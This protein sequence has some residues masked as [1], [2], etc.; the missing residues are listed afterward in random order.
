M[1][2]D[3]SESKCP[4]G[5]PCCERFADEMMIWCSTSLELNICVIIGNPHDRLITELI[6]FDFAPMHHPLPINIDLCTLLNLV[7]CLL[8]DKMASFIL[9]RNTVMDIYSSFT[10]SLKRRFVKNTWQFFFTPEF[11][12][13]DRDRKCALSIYP[14]LI[15]SIGTF[16]LLS[17]SN[18][19]ERN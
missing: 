9:L 17:R 3:A 13:V 15:M 6:A 2:L 10:S 18:F 4:M 7:F 1:I 8:S 11:T 19:S 16:I 14:K 5:K 12:W